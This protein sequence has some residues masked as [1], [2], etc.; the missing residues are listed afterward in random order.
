M[1]FSTKFPLRSVP[2]PNLD[3][4][5]SAV[6]TWLQFL[7]S[8]NP[9]YARHAVIIVWAR[10]W[11]DSHG[12]VSRVWNTRAEFEP[13]LR[14]K[15]CRS[16]LTIYRRRWCDIFGIWC[17]KFEHALS[18]KIRYEF[19]EYVIFTSASLITVCR[20]AQPLYVFLMLSSSV[21]R[22]YSD[23]GSAKTINRALKGTTSV[24]MM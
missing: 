1:S 7:V 5:G 13:H 22:D 11:S 20:Y 2:F 9:K 15:S 17:T 23:V 3:A 21:T 12:L 6:R 16:S 4:I 18:L 14:M 19:I 8:C 24:I 10:I